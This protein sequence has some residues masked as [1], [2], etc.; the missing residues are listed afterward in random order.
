MNPMAG[1]PRGSLR[2]GLGSAVA[3]AFIIVGTI[4]LCL[5][6]EFILLPLSLITERGNGGPLHGL[7]QAWARWIIHILPFG[8][9]Q[10]Q[11]LEKINWGK[12]Y[13]VVSNHQSMLDILVVLAKLP[14]HFKFIAKQELFW[15][16]FFGWHL[17]LARYLP[18]KRGDPESGKVCMDKARG[19]LR[20]GVSVVFFPEGTRSP[21]GEIHEFKAGA[22]K[23]ALEEGID[24][25]PL[26]IV[27]TREAIPKHS[28]RIEKRT[29]LKLVIED[30]VSVRE[31]KMEH[32]NPLRD[33]VRAGIIREFVKQR[34][35]LL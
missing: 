17:A 33:E 7:S 15:I 10:V 8:E 12:A 18:L 27:G 13:V 21:D 25:L 19:W 20:K 6:G 28:W 3:W 2:S 30:P 34:K 14:I 26:V 29:P 31:L 22:F 9:I 4:A 1:D 5:F 16:P 24:I 32:L 35:E 23:V 11:G